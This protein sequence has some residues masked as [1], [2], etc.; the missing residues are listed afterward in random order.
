[1]KH[2][3]SFYK[4]TITLPDK[5][6]TKM[7]IK[8]NNFSEYRCKDHQKNIRLNPAICKSIMYHDQVESIPQIQR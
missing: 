5:E 7:K 1:M 4:A 2:P 6:T 3:N 8:A